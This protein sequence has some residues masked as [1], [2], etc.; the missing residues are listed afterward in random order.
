MVLVHD[1]SFL[2]FQFKSTIFPHDQKQTIF[3][4][5]QYKTIYVFFIT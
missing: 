4:V 2:N 1:Q 5:I 3:S